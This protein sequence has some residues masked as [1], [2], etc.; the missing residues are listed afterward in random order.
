MS[1]RKLILSGEQ[2]V[3]P[4]SVTL[5]ESE[6]EWRVEVTSYREGARELTELRGTRKETEDD[7]S[8]AAIS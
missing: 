6:S 2:S 5:E 1:G 4:F 8:Q 3:A 7:V